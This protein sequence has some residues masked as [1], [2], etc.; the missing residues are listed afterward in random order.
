MQYLNAILFCK[1]YIIVHSKPRNETAKKIGTC[2]KSDWFLTSNLTTSTI[3]TIDSSVK[4][5]DLHLLLKPPI[6]I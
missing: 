1:I 3:K 4:R 6:P 2:R 5:R